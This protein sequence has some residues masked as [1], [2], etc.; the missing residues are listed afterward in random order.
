MCCSWEAIAGDEIMDGRTR[1][2][3]AVEDAYCGKALPVEAGEE[4]NNEVFDLLMQQLLGLTNGGV[5]LTDTVVMSG[6]EQVDASD[7]DRRSKEEEIRQRYG[8]LVLS[9]RPK[10]QDAL[11]DAVDENPGKVALQSWRELQSFA[12]TFPC[13]RE[14]D[15]LEHHVRYHPKYS[16]HELQFRDLRA[17]E[18]RLVNTYGL[19]RQST[20]SK[21]N[22]DSSSEDIEAKLYRYT[23]NWGEVRQFIS[24][25]LK[26]RV[27]KGGMPLTPAELKRLEAGHSDVKEFVLRLNVLQQK[28][29]HCRHCS[30]SYWN[31]EDWGLPPH[32]SEAAPEERNQRLRPFVWG[33][34]ADKITRAVVETCVSN[35]VVRAP[36]NLVFKDETDK[37][38]TV[39]LGGDGDQYARSILGEAVLT[40][41]RM[42]E[43]LNVKV[44]LSETATWT[45]LQSEQKNLDV[46][47]ALGTSVVERLAGFLQSFYSPLAAAL[48]DVE[49]DREKWCKS[50]AVQLLYAVQRSGALFT[51]EKSR[52]ARYLDGSKPKFTPNMI[53]LNHALHRKIRNEFVEDGTNLLQQLYQH[54]RLPPMISP[55]A[56]RTLEVPDQGGF[57]T[58]GLQA[59]KPMIS[60]SSGRSHQDAPRFTAS[61]E[62]VEV[63]NGL[64]NTTWTVDKYTAREGQPLDTYSMA[65]TVLNHEL[66]EG[67]LSHLRIVADGEKATLEFDDLAAVK[68]I[69]HGQVREWYDTFAFIEHLTTT[70][71]GKPHFWHA[72]QF[73]WRGR[74]N[75]M[76]P[77]L[78]P[79]NDD[80]CRGLLRF[81]E[82]VRL[83][84][85]GL[86]WLG[87]F[88]V[89]LC[90]DLSGLGALEKGDAYQGLIEKLEDKRWTS[91][92]EVAKDPLFL[93]MLDQLLTMPPLES[94]VHWGQGHV[95]RKKAEGFQRYA[96]MKEFHRVMN[97]GGV[98][99]ETN[100]PVHLDASSSIYQHASAMLKDTA[101]GQKVNVVAQDDGGPSD[102][103]M[104]VVHELSAIWDQQGFLTSFE[105]EQATK[106]TIKGEVLKRS[107]AKGP[108]MTKG[109]GAGADSM[110]RVMLTHNGDEDG[111]MG[112]AEK[113]GKTTLYAHQ[114]STLGFLHGLKVP[115]ELHNDIAKEVVNGYN[116]AIKNVLPS[117]DNV[118]KLLKKLVGTQNKK[119]KAPLSWTLADGSQVVNSKWKE[120]RSVTVS[121]WSG[122]RGVRDSVRGKLSRLRSAPSEGLRELIPPT[123]T[124]PVNFDALEKAFG[125]EPAA[126]PLLNDLK[127]D[128][129]SRY[130]DFLSS[131]GDH[132]VRSACSDEYGGLPWPELRKALGLPSAKNNEKPLSY[133]ELNTISTELVDALKT[134]V[135]P[136]ERRFSY[137]ETS[138]LRDFNAE[139]R[140]IAPNFVH[141]FDALHMRRFVR[142]M[143]REGHH[144]LWSVHDSFGCHAN[145][146]DKMRAI[147]RNQFIYIHKLGAD[148]PN[149]LWSLMTSL[150]TPDE[151]PKYA[152]LGAMSHQDINSEYFVN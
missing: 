68:K 147:L 4:E 92:D 62:A 85:T 20:Y 22:I 60:D 133:D 17:L 142:D 125:K 89:S 101:M 151:Q 21:V 15:G 80:V 30:K 114:D 94:Y 127:Q 26:V 39:M 64:Q 118:L 37:K 145:H 58:P 117:F 103:Y 47:V 143:Q 93:E 27:A 11:F 38:H 46:Y 115:F 44:G 29:L 98:G 88:T 67:I 144:D 146:V 83:D 79:Q 54:E 129:T 59:K 110:V 135:Y 52:S 33:A 111:E 5:D 1:A 126:A 65:R 74:M 149:V 122:A 34:M 76:T 50:R 2:Q 43:Q 73:D 40:G 95:F 99:A 61:D 53:R 148:E 63:L 32:V 42:S 91:Y 100:L 105:L 109:Y 112:V 72:W 57:L 102:V 10:I 16:N 131:L 134:Y 113:D 107:V 45:A 8:E 84:E 23:V 97:E 121:P 120:N 12:Q 35:A 56:K 123:L 6:D 13:C 51:V 82:P 140:G 136:Y 137:Q 14:K 28:V 87:R 138:L 81:A 25:Q 71:T 24:E 78:S 132:D 49:S 96:A 55:P 130:Q 36:K 3:I 108:V 41:F 106:D 19:D 77:M 139:R 104:H 119:N 116:E 150:L 70:Y 66:Q 18:E 31:Q 86:K 124:L 128:E 48:S 90:R 7:H 141:S 9:L 69:R 75:T 152:K